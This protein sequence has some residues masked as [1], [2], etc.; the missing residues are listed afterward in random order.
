[1]ALAPDKEIKVV[2]QA[3]VTTPDLGTLTTTV[4]TAPSADILNVSFSPSAS[5]AVQA[6]PAVSTAPALAP[7]KTL[8]QG[9]EA[10]QSSSSTVSTVLYA[11]G[12]R[13]FLRRREKN[14]RSYY[15][16]NVDR[17][18]GERIWTSRG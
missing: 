13:E 10:T 4:S 5:T 3:A 7:A 1:M 11:V 15:H 17:C 2:K 6:A 16:W 9:V 18:R 14:H 12:C 8:E